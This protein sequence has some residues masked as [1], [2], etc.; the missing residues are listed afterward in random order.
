MAPT[1]VMPEMAFD[2]DMSGVWRRGGTL[3]IR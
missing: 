2:P 1:R 3:L